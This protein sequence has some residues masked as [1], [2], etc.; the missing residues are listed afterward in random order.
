MLPLGSCGD[1]ESEPLVHT[2]P[3]TAVEFGAPRIFEL[4][5][6]TSELVYPCEELG[7]PLPGVSKE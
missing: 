4:K 3:S 1:N 5:F 2:L 6:P 7:G